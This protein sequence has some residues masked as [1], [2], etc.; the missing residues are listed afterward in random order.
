M[1]LAG[2]L[3]TAPILLRF[4][5]YKNN[6]TEERRYTL[7][8][9]EA[10][11]FWAAA[12][13]IVSWWLALI[14]DLIPVVFLTLI[15][16]GWGHIS[17]GVKDSVELFNGIKNTIK[18]IL[19]A[20]SMWVS[21]VI[22]FEGIFK[23]YNGDDPDASSASYTPRVRN[24]PFSFRVGDT[25]WFHLTSSI[26]IQVYQ[27]IQFLFFLAL[28]VSV[29]RMISQ[30][31][32]QTFHRTAYKERLD[33]VN[34]TLHVIETLRDHKP[35][36]SHQKK[37]S[38]A[39]TPILFSKSASRPVSQQNS[40][41]PSLVVGFKDDGHMADSENED[42][43]KGKGKRRSALFLNPG[44]DGGDPNDPSV[45]MGS[46][47]SY[48][49]APRSGANTPTRR[50][51]SHDADDAGAAAVVTQAAKALKTAVLHDARNMRGKDGADKALVWD[52]TNSTEA[53][54]L[55]RLIY[56]TFRVG[57]RKYLLPQDFH[58]A[59]PTPEEAEK[60]FRVFDQD[61]NGDISRREIKTVL[62]KVY[63][64]RRFL[65]RSVRD[66]GAALKTLDRILLIFALVIL[67]FISLSVFGVDVTKSLTSVY[68]IGIAASFIFKNAAS[69]AFDAIMFLFVTQYVYILEGKGAPSDDFF[70]RSQ[71]VRYR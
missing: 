30:A 20:A 33:A 57:K 35:V 43:P 61:D 21:W 34:E 22:I 56:L 10:W 11:L 62:L 7:N 55:A 16:I 24:F 13:L 53:K 58:P 38:N 26:S 1:F 51:D 18:P 19:Y 14:I 50:R 60:A 37:P 63:K 40:R 42:S 25:E 23:L 54:R 36:R 66:I 69:N 68:S 52:V 8:N 4:Y 6:P 67:F 32:A 41:P 44:G 48:P 17:E 64:E 3:I 46:V 28:V 29:Q 45:S 12:N 65:S 5:W 70:D 71:S 2:L 27:V 15:S 31:I 39:R 47:H 9:I 49:P 59:F